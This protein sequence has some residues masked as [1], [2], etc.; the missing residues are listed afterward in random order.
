M[1]YGLL[2][3]LFLKILWCVWNQTSFE[4]Y[5]QQIVSLSTKVNIF[6]TS[7]SLWIHFHVFYMH[8]C[9]LSSWLPILWFYIS[10]F[11][12]LH[13]LHVCQ[14][15]RGI[16]SL[17]LYMFILLLIWIIDIWIQGLTIEGDLCIYTN[18]SDF[19]LEIT[20]LSCC[21]D[22]NGCVNFP[23]SHKVAALFWGWI[24]TDASLAWDSSS[25]VISLQ[26][27]E[28]SCI[29]QVVWR[30]AWCSRTFRHLIGRFFSMLQKINCVI[31]AKLLCWVQCP[32]DPTLVWPVI[33]N[34]IIG[35]FSDGGLCL[36]GCC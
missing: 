25:T 32:S 23:L 24:Q 15:W 9:F 30:S 1:T 7:I 11:C 29:L 14:S 21:P 27:R 17:L 3:S 34:D 10:L 4:F 20:T 26:Y 22:V 35:W 2:S 13:L 19:P 6:I 36:P 12:T 5:I 31:L 18:I 8:E 28:C 16:S 33:L